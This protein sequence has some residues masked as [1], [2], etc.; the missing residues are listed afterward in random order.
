MLLKHGSRLTHASAQKME[1]LVEW[2][3]ARRPRTPPR[4]L[5]SFILEELPA[6]MREEVG[7]HAGLRPLL[8]LAQANQTF[9]DHVDRMFVFIFNRDITDA[10][11]PPWSDKAAIRSMR[12]MVL[13]DPTGEYY[14]PQREAEL[15]Y[16]FLQLLFLPRPYYIY[17]LAEARQQK[18]NLCAIYRRV[19][20]KLAFRFV[21]ELE[22]AYRNATEELREQ[23]I[24]WIDLLNANRGFSAVIQPPTSAFWLLSGRSTLTITTLETDAPE[25]LPHTDAFRRLAPSIDRLTFDNKVCDAWFNAF[26]NLLLEVSTHFEC[27]M[28]WDNTAEGGIKRARVAGLNTLTRPKIIDMEPSS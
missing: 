1:A 25:M 15:P 21:L 3:W 11:A 17:D 6:E 16:I 13:N 12:Q 9:R 14:S 22:L 23:K 10:L 26:M 19:C 18:L 7:R 8:R 2:M 24:S 28:T 5:P 27:V 4:D 20:Q